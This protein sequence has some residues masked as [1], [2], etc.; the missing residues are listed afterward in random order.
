MSTP[1]RHVVL[2]SGATRG[3]GRELVTTY[4]SRPNYTVVASVRDLDAENAKSLNDIP[5]GED[6]RL[7]I[8]KIDSKSKTDA[9]DA[10]TKL[11]IKEEIE[12]F[13]VVI[14]A[15]GIAKDYIEV[16]DAN[17]DDLQEMFEVNVL[18]TIRLCQAVLPYFAREP[19]TF[20]KKPIPKFVTI[21]PT[22][23]STALAE[24]AKSL[25]V[26]NY[27]GT[28]AMLNFLQRRNQFEEVDDEIC[29]FVVSPGAV[30]TDLALRAMK[31]LGLP[32]DTLGPVDVA[33]K[34]IVEVI[35]EATIPTHGGK[36]F[37]FDKTELPW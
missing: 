34:G 3:I 27:G 13:D 1:Y 20:D 10:I 2:I 35:D 16:V 11:N 22:L 25:L 15:A 8:I 9:L 6:T 17:I 26:G 4:L 33:V 14:A 5:R 24:E 23:S 18:G 28:K 36:F 32:E 29:Y 7:H 19:G 30:R 37:N 12:E 31:E 21:S